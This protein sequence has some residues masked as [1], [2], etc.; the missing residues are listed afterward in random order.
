M[1]LPQLPIHARGHF[2]DIGAR[3][4]PAA[5]EPIA[6]RASLQVETTLPEINPARS[7]NGWHREFCVELLGEGAARIFVRAVQRSSFRAA[8]L[9]RAILFHRLDPRF[10][11]LAGCVEALQSELEGLA[12][13]ARRALP[14]KENLFITVGYDR[15]AWDRVEQAVERWVRR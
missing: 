13:T 7:L 2:N 14:S 6:S 4:Q 9:Q 8:E 5:P 1:N 3:Q 12:A 11:D 15:K 10:D